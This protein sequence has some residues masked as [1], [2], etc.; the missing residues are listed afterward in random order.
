LTSF[1]LGFWGG[2]GESPFGRHAC[3]PASIAGLS[4]SRIKPT[5]KKTL[6]SD[7]RHDLTHKHVK[8]CPKSGG[9]ESSQLQPVPLDYGSS[10]RARRPSTQSLGE[11]RL[12]AAF[13][14]TTAREVACQAE[15]V[16]VSLIFVTFCKRGFSR[17]TFILPKNRKKIN[18]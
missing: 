5:I 6:S 18:P 12:D 15:T 17:A 8:I 11:D 13:C 1:V 7:I 14:L 3:V 4:V 10:V 9:N 2:I 16:F